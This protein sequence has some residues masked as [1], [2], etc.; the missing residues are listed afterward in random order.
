MAEGKKNNRKGSGS[1]VERAI[2]GKGVK[3]RNDEKRKEKRAVVIFT[4]WALRRKKGEGRKDSRDV[5]TELRG[6][7][8][9]EHSQLISYV[10]SK[11]NRK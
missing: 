5:R 6:Q 9:E 10:E 2:S 3:R 11:H 8:G 1:S 4:R 7:E